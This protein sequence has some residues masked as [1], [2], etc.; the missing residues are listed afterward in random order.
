MTYSKKNIRKTAVIEGF[1]S[2]TISEFYDFEKDDWIFKDYKDSAR[3]FLYWEMLHESEYYYLMPNVNW[4]Y[5]SEDDRKKYKPILERLGL[6]F[7]L[8]KFHKDLTLSSKRVLECGPICEITSENSGNPG[9]KVIKINLDFDDSIIVSEFETW[10]KKFKDR[11]VKINHKKV[12]DIECISLL[13]GLAYMRL[14]HVI[15]P[16]TLKKLTVDLGSKTKDDL[17][18]LFSIKL[19]KKPNF[20]KLE[21]AV[22]KNS[23]DLI[24]KFKIY[25][26]EHFPEA[27]PRNCQPSS[28]HKTP[29]YIGAGYISTM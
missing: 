5:L 6:A 24:K 29:Y 23:Y 8:K 3:A 17:E 12:K 9:D 10:L 1:E 25:F 13:K 4:H 26:K 14:L 16:R 15:T 20:Y 21:D 18:T 2:I 7:E 11:S 27:K 22:E 28:K 19:S